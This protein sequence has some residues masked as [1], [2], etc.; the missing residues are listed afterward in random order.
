MKLS[1]S[2]ILK[3]VK[4]K[5]TTRT[6]LSHLALNLKTGC[7]LYTGTLN[8]SGYG[9]MSYG[10][11]AHRFSYAMAHGQ[12]PQKG[13]TVS[14]I[15]HNRNCVA[16]AHLIS[17]SQKDNVGRSAKLGRVRGPS[18]GLKKKMVQNGKQGFQKVISDA[19]V[20]RIKKAILKGRSNHSLARQY[21]VSQP[22]ISEIRNG[23]KRADVTIN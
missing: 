9:I 16:P 4:S 5:R 10:L 8:E 22:F 11:L 7:V 6:F 20:R 1:D 18:N 19:V 23:K 14:H 13:R 17:E 2:R 15:C 12:L 21:G 3:L